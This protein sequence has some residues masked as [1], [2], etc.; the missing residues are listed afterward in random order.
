MESHSD[1]P[2]QIKKHFAGSTNTACMVSVKKIK[3]EVKKGGEE[4]FFTKGLVDKWIDRGDTLELTCTVIGDP[5]PEI[6]WL[7]DS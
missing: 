4:P 3:E 5:K 7:V 6:K 1:K 2:E